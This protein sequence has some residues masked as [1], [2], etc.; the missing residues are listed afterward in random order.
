MAAARL[1][2]HVS[3]SKSPYFKITWPAF[4]RV[5]TRRCSH[6]GSL[7]FPCINTV[8][9]RYS[10]VENGNAANTFTL[11]LTAVMLVTE[12]GQNR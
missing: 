5:D 6:H 3:H 1:A 9:D 12:T 11:R 7:L 10:P 2:K 8:G 4:S